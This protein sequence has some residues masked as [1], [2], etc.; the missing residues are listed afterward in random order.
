MVTHINGP[1]N[2]ARLEG[3]IDGI[4]KTVYLFMDFHSDIANQ[5]KCNPVIHN[6][7]P[8]ESQDVVE[9]IRSNFKKVLN[10]N[11]MYDFFIEMYKYTTDT[12]VTK[13]RYIDDIVDLMSAMFN[14]KKIK[15]KEK[16]TSFKNIRVHYFDIRDVISKKMDTYFNECYMIFSQIKK[17]EWLVKDGMISLNNKLIKIVDEL[18]LFKKDLLSNKKS[19]KNSR[20]HLFF[21]I[22]EKYHS[23]DIK[24]VLT[25]F[26]KNTV[27]PNTDSLKLKLS[28]LAFKVKNL[29]DA[30]LRFTTELPRI[31]IQGKI[32]YYNEKNATI[33]DNLHLIEL[34]VTDIDKS[35]VELM[36]SVVD[37]FTLRRI[38]DK[39]YI[40]NIIHYGG[41]YHSCSI[42]YILCTQF[43]FKVTHMAK[44]DYIKSLSEFSNVESVQ[45]VVKKV[46]PKTNLQCSDISE[47]PD[48]FS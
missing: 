14:I 3:T 15:D 22:N 9:Y 6:F 30:S 8:L 28:K 47:F 32:E 35:F 31:E 45:D 46:Y 10:N 21:K 20:G 1:I 40:S 27:I 38:L 23:S 24:K 12:Y 36:A 41:I 5:T 11:K 34:E 13:G 44:K 48:K 39:E 26:I 29:S 16:V 43:G 25:D 37:I 17:N 7:D 33:S 4:K 2:V 19:K 42:I 18:E